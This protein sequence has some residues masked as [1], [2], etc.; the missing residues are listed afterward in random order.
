MNKLSKLNKLRALK[1]TKIMSTLALIVSA[2]VFVSPSFASIDLTHPIDSIDPTHPIF[3]STNSNINIL[4]KKDVSSGKDVFRKMSFWNHIKDDGKWGGLQQAASTYSIPK[5]E[6]IAKCENTVCPLRMT[7]VKKIVDWHQQHSTGIEITQLSDEG[8][9]FGDIDSFSIELTI[10]KEHTYI[11]SL[12]QLKKTYQAY[13]KAGELANLADFDHGKVNIMFVFYEKNNTNE[14][15]AK[16]MASIEIDIEFDA[17][18]HQISRENGRLKIKIPVS[19]MRFYNEYHYQKSP[20]TQT[21][22]ATKLILGLTITAET[23]SG[24]VLRG[25]MKQW[26]DSIPETYK[27]VDVSF[28]ELLIN[29]K[30]HA[31]SE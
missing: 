2:L 10:H 29:T 18:N 15:D 17:D 4:R 21:E 28:H 12:E 6:V 3:T 30:K 9:R 16:V 25:K 7:L 13:L 1:L 8:L 14:V 23:A 20:Q 31:T 26:S 22:I 19:L 27:E 11:P 24:S 5:T